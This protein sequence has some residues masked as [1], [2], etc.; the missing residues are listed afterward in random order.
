MKYRSTRG[1]GSPVSFSGATL[2]GL[3]EDGGLL[4]PESTPETD[5][6]SR[7]RSEN[8]TYP[9][10]VF[11]TIAPFIGDHDLNLDDVA[12]L[13]EDAFSP[14]SWKGTEIIS[15][16]KMN[17]GT[18][19]VF[20]DKG[21]TLAFKDF[22][23]M[24][25]GR[26]IQYVLKVRGLRLVIV[27][28]TSGDTG[29]AAIE[30]FGGLENV[31][32]FV[33][34]PQD[35]TSIFQLKQMTTASYENV[36]PIAIK[37]PFDACQRIV[38]E[39]LN[40]KAFVALLNLSGVNSINWARIVMQ[41]AYYNWLCALVPSDDLL[42]VIVPTGNFG[43]IHAGTRARMTGA[44]INQL[45]LAANPNR[46]LVDFV[47]SGIYM[48]V[49]DDDVVKTV[50]PSI[51]IG[52]ASNPERAL[53]DAVNQN[54]ARVRELMGRIKT[55]GS[56]ALTTVEL[57]RLQ[58]MGLT[59]DWV[60]E[61]ECLEEIRRVFEESGILL[62]PHGAV[63][64]AVARRRQGSRMKVILATA[65]P[66]KFVPAMRRAGITIDI[67]RPPRFVGLE[68]RPDERLQVLQPDTEAVKDY[69]RSVCR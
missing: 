59:A 7:I 61:K 9:E 16:K 31:E 23:M 69:I 19:V 60:T 54:G 35:G 64:S 1:G 20:L 44:P 27:V 28:A 40:D 58:A 29:P 57:R 24:P 46:M 38:K 4:V 34:F 55:D 49:P 5:I 51:D 8:L 22:P 6:V 66:A 65:A 50:S 32:L 26:L 47:N 52:S 2:M 37:G 10:T 18:Y 33:L 21:P 25:V 67:P 53:Y 45:V 62:D 43:N 12:A 14:T 15:L 17:A 48:P 63:A 41:V 36:H 11:Q 30:A 3:A 56:Y 68:E 42:D 13:I 39:M